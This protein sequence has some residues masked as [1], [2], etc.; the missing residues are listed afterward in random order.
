MI[1]IKIDAKQIKRLIEATGKAKKKFPKE[2]AAAINDVSR[3]TKVKIGKDIRAVVAIKTAEAKKPISIKAKASAQQLSATVTLKKTKR[4]G[5]RHF[6]ARQ[7]KTGVSYKISKTSGRKS[8]A[9]A[10]QGPT[11]NIR[12]MSWRGNVFKRVGESRLPIIQ[13]K[14]VSAFGAYAKNELSGPQVKTIEAELVK[15]MERRIKLN[16]LRASGLVST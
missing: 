2:L 12:K 10:F 13:L 6:G 1:E 5:L 14:G 15:Q 7:T 16:V 8:V 11:P 3:K 9:G 4:L